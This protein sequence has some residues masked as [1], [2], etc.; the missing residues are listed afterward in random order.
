MLN[1]MA[2]VKLR[3]THVDAISN[4]L[5]FE[6]VVNVV[7]LLHDTDRYLLG[8]GLRS[9]LMVVPAGLFE[10]N[11]IQFE[12]RVRILSSTASFNPALADAKS[13]KTTERYAVSRSNITINSKLS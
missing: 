7:I 6:G 11:S 13:V 5:V 9:S 4:S 3:C 1:L 2:S 10:I 12:V 8:G